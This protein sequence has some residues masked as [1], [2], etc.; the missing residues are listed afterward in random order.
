MAAGKQD[1]PQPPNF[2]E[3]RRGALTGVSLCFA[4]SRSPRVGPHAAVYSSPH[5]TSL[6]MFSPLVD[7]TSLQKDGHILSQYALVGQLG[8]NPIPSPEF[9]NEYQSCSN[10][11]NV[12]QV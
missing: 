10:Q 12:V 6:C 9:V 7:T 8:T 1:F 11:M 2:A 4:A 3:G 5:N